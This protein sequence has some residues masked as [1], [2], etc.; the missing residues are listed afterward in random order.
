MFIPAMSPRLP[1]AAARACS[2]PAP[3]E[4][5]S[6][7]AAVAPDPSSCLRVSPPFSFSDRSMRSSQLEP[8]GFD[9]VTLRKMAIALLLEAAA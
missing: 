7:D 4:S 6:A 5:S 3:W 1:F 2:I 8:C 9:E